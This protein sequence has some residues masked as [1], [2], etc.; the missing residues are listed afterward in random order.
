MGKILKNYSSMIAMLSGVVLGGVCG[1]L[2]KDV[3]LAV[4]PVG[5]IFLNLLFVLVVPMVF[6]SVTTAFCKMR[7]GA[8]IGR[9][10]SRTL[11][12]FVLMW[13]AAGIIAYLCGAIAGPLGEGFSTADL[14]S[15][16]AKQDTSAAQAVVGALTVGDFPQLFSKFSLLPLII[17]SAL[18]G[19]GVSAAEEKGAAFAAFLES[20]GEVTVKAMGVLMKA[21]PI[22]LGCYF[23][24][25]IA[26]LGGELLHG[27]LRVFVIYC[28]CA[29]VFFFIVNPMLVFSRKGKEGVR[30]FWRSILPPTIT[31]LAS[32]SS[33]A[34]MPLNIQA[35]KE[36]GICDSVAESV[37]P[38]GTNL[39]KAGSVMLDTFKIM[40]LLLLSGASIT[41]PASALLCIG[42]AI[43]AAVVSG[44]VTNGGVTGELLICSILGIDPAMVGIIMIIG[45]ICDIPATVVNSQSTVVAAALSEQ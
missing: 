19:T 14:P 28:C 22:G 45:T 30:A 4:K 29:A 9:T 6:F 38:L 43:L 1:I 3:A 16:A 41:T 23:A 39:L 25:T 18:L 15:L 37:V 27:Y 44:A 40:F 20:G 21:G 31:A 13:I 26:Q 34:A 7:S 5:D 42:V 32:S 33:S 36:M 2:W 17:F 10:L 8:G 12:A 11:G 24:G 35:A